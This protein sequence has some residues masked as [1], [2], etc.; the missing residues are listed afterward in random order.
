[1]KSPIVII[2]I[3]DYLEITDQIPHLF[4]LE[5]TRSAG[6]TVRDI[7]GHEGVFNCIHEIVGPDENA[8]FAIRDTAAYRLRSD[9]SGNKRAFFVFISGRWR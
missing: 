1:M 2:G 4:P 8:D 5:K 6:N 7:V 3:G 9:G